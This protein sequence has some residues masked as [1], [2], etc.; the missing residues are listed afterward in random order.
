LN[1]TLSE[2]NDMSHDDTPT[3]DAA[4]QPP[5]S[6]VG[7]FIRT[8]SIPYVA[9][10]NACW[11]AFSLAAAVLLCG[12]RVLADDGLR[13]HIDSPVPAQL[14]EYS[15]QV[16]RA[17]SRVLVFSYTHPV[18]DSPCDRVIGGPTYQ[19]FVIAGPFPD[20]SPFSLSHLTGDLT[21]T[22]QPGNRGGQTGGFWAVLGGGLTFLTPGLLL[23][24]LGGYGEDATMTRAGIGFMVGG[25]LAAIIGGV[26]LATSGTKIKLHQPGG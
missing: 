22:V 25:G 5:D 6:R 18:C 24:N 8:G 14:A 19:R 1:K 13:V 11:I 23:L 7:S 26:L 16:S 2:A 3:T 17:G 9:P 12:S 20:S 21:I 10:T 4:K 15:T